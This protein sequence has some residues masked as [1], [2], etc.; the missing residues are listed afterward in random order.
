MSGKKVINDMATFI[1]LSSIGAFIVSILAL[2][3]DIYSTAMTLLVYFPLEYNVQ[4]VSDMLGANIL[5]IMISLTQI[6]TI[7][8]ALNDDFPVSQRIVAALLYMFS[9]LFDGFTDVVFRSEYLTGNIYIAIGVTVGFFTFGAEM[10]SGFS[11]M[12]IGKFWRRGISDIMLHLARIKAFFNNVKKEQESYRRVAQ[13]GEDRYLGEREK[14]VGGG[15]YDPK[16]SQSPVVNRQGYTGA[17]QHRQQPHQPAQ[18]FRK[19]EQRTDELPPDF[20]RLK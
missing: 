1:L 12:L 10:L 14:E 15:G 20:T 13:K 2:K 16:V 8:I 19:P 4:P 6:V 9:M 11:G 18:Q 17:N 5:A 3:E 7:A